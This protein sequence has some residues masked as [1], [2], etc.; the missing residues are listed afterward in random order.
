MHLPMNVHT[1]ATVQL[2][3]SVDCLWEFTL[4]TMGV[5]ELELGPS[6]PAASASAS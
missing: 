1:Q 2:W 4:S 3:S 5:P 6:Q